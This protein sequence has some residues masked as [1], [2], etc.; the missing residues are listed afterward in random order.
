M[1][2]PRIHI[3]TCLLIVLVANFIPLITAS[4]SRHDSSALAKF[5]LSPDNFA[6]NHL[7]LSSPHNK[8]AL[9]PKR[10]T[11]HTATIPGSPG[12]PTWRVRYIE[13]ASTLPINVAATAM[14]AFLSSGLQR[15]RQTSDSALREVLAGTAGEFRIKKGIFHLNFMTQSGRLNREFIEGV[16]EELLEST[17]LGWVTQFKSEWMDTVGGFTVWITCT[18]GMGFGDTGLRPGPID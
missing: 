1:F 2:Q 8:I 14:E 16:I 11:I 13:I 5:A 10:A 6:N 18:L 15:V 3:P 12:T 4:T 17:R 7:L 9:M